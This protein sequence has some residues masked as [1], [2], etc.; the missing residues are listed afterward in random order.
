MNSI[1]GG[2][3]FRLFS[4]QRRKG[5]ENALFI[6]ARKKNQEIKSSRGLDTGAP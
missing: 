5:R 1:W 4:L 6:G 3:E 2:G